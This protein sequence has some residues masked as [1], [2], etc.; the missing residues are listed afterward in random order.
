MKILLHKLHRSG[1]SAEYSRRAPERKGAPPTS[2]NLIKNFKRIP[3][4]CHQ[5]YRPTHIN[6]LAAEIAPQNQQSH[7]G[8]CQAWAHWSN[9]SLARPGASHYHQ[10]SVYSTQQWLP[11]RHGLNASSQ[12]LILA[13]VR[14]PVM[15]RPM[16]GCRMWILMWSLRTVAPLVWV[17]K[18]LIGT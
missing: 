18:R 3:P 1:W 6:W 14:T 8:E 13:L 7:V 5:W 15:H 17:E 16:S 10:G 12:V 2:L 11:W 9:H 4:S